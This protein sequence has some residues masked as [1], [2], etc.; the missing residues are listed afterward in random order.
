VVRCVVIGA[1]PAGLTA[2]WEL[3]RLGLSSLVFEA[4]TLVGGIARTVEYK[5]YR[6]DI[7]GH[8]FFTKIEEIQRIWEEVLGED[9]L[10]RPRLSRIYY[11][12]KYFDYPLRPMNALVGLGPVEAARIGTSFAWAQLFPSRR[13]DTFE[14]WVTNRFGRRLFELFFKSYT[15]KV[16]GISCAEIRAEWAAQRI[17]NLDLAATVKNALLGA[18]AAGGGVIPTL[19]EEFHYPR[20]GPG[21]M[22]EQ[23][24][25]RLKQ[26]GTETLLGTRVERVRHAGGRV[27]GVDVRE[28]EGG[29]R[30]VDADHVFCSMPLRDLVRALEPKAPESVRRAAERLR[31]RDFLTVGLVV[32]RAD[33]F[34]DNWIYVHSD[35]VRL[36]RIQNFKNWSPDMVPDASRTGLGL[37]YFVQEGDELWSAPDAELL[38]LGAREC[39]QLGLLRPEEVV[40]GTVIRMRK[41]YPVYDGAYRDALFEVRRFLD[42]LEGL[43]SIGR[44]AQHRYNNQDHSMLTAL[45]AARNAAQGAGHD[46][47]AVNVDEDYHEAGPSPGRSGDRLTPERTPGPSVED[48]VREA[49]ARWDPVALGAA[50]GIVAGVGL[51]LATAVLL[52][53]GGETVGPTLSLLANYFVTYD[54]SWGGALLGTVEAGAGGFVFGWILAKLLNAVTLSEQRALEARIE[55]KALDLLAGDDT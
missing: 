20:L 7:G 29:R 15:E 42:G 31:Y 12:G 47:W 26:R 19:I 13:E 52:L 23:M 8:R 16:W 50:T 24:A 6:F 9:F 5:G 55:S 51:F 49:F 41:A 38:A 30:A 10:R 44:N 32:D 35:A 4:D 54:V 3:D 17:K 2:A 40:D 28:P 21:Q 18:R 48:V 34:P 25:S 1:G 39:E 46:V 53:R 36:G 33:L 37:E 43:H 14:E 27:V 45:Y 11:D 22:W